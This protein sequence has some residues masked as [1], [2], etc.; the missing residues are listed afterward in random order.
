VAIVL[1][2]AALG[3]GTALTAHRRRSLPPGTG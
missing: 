2:V 3:I 1:L